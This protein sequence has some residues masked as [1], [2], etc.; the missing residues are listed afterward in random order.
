MTRACIKQIE[1]L[2][3]HS[4]T[5]YSITKHIFDHALILHNYAAHIN[6]FDITV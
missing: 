6:T 5:V 1:M 4:E 2:L 3:L